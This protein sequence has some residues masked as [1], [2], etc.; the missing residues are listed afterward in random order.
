MILVA[1]TPYNISKRQPRFFFPPKKRRSR[2][3]PADS[4]CAAVFECVD[5]YKI[6]SFNRTIARKDESLTDLR[7]EHSR[8]DLLSCSD[9]SCNRSS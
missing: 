3:I 5:T 2:S 4:H 1:G 8:K 9:S 7:D 6:E